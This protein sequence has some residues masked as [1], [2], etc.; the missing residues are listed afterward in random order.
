M[1]ALVNVSLAADRFTRVIAGYSE[2][3]TRRRCGHRVD[4]QPD[5]PG[6]RAHGWR[7]G[8]SLQA[9][10]DLYGPLLRGDL[11]RRFATLERRITIGCLTAQCPERC[12]MPRA[13]PVS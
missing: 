1:G 6:R 2:T 13:S 12:R 3:L 8:K 9:V 10:L 7:A 11:W 4:S 5:Q